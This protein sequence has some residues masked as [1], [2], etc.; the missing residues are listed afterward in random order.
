M[1]LIPRGFGFSDFFDSFL[2]D[3]YYP[4]K[5]IN[6][7]DIYEKDN[8]YFLELEVP[9]LN[10]EDIKIESDEGYLIISASKKEEKEDKD[11]NYI[12]KERT[13]ESIQRKFY[14]GNIDES[15][16]KA[17]FKDGILN[18]SFPKEEKESTK[19]QITIN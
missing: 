7:C 13:F 5:N 3:G 11:K 9:G 19:K 12:R 4:T 17:E 14:V 15:K 16:I 1:D 18:V 6:K 8:Y 2:T 10:K